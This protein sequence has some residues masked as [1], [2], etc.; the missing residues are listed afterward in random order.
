VF[1]FSGFFSSFSGS[2]VHNLNEFLSLGILGV[3]LS[4]LLGSKGDEV[5]KNLLEFGDS[6]F[7]VSDFGVVSVEV[8][9]TSGL[10]GSVVGIVFLLVGDVSVFNFIE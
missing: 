4:L 1:E 10:V 6:L 2:F 3:S 9:I 5:I 8:L 7:D